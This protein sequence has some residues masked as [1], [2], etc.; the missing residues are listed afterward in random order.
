[1]S[2]PSMPRPGMSLPS[3]PMPSMSLPSVSLPN[4][5]LFQW[6]PYASSSPAAPQDANTCSA[7]DAS[8]AAESAGQEMRL[9]HYSSSSRDAC[10]GSAPAA[11][12]MHAPHA[13]AV[14][15]SGPDQEDPQRP[16]GSS[17]AEG[18]SSIGACTNDLPISTHA[19]G[20]GLGAAGSKTSQAASP[21]RSAGR[22]LAPA[23]AIGEPC[24]PQA[25]NTQAK[26]S[27]S[28]RMPRC[29]AVMLN[30]FRSIGV[31]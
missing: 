16:P 1:M 10:S 29:G 27:T 24:T 19:A 22:E 7:T 5:S 4:L 2:L 6:V 30:P 21:E 18:E 15:L 13:S 17:V 3:V 14:T 12:T 25:G 23:K 28:S 20:T 31:W 26:A 8:S 9:L 11:E